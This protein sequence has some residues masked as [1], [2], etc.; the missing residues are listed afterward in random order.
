MRFN[1]DVARD[2]LM[3]AYGSLTQ[4]AAELAAKRCRNGGGSYRT[5]YAACLDELR[6][7]ALR[8]ANAR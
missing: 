4:Q 5:C 2:H 1:D 8:E 6:Q 7:K 3:T